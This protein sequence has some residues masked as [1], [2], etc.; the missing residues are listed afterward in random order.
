ML[1]GTYDL[2][3]YR[4]DTTRI[5][6]VLWHDAA[7]TQPVDVSGAVAKAQIRDRPDSTAVVA[8]LLCGGSGNTVT[9]TVPDA[10]SAKLGKNGFWDLQLTWS[11]G[12]VQTVVA[13]LVY[14]EPDVTRGTS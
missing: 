5:D 14:A 4:G 7:K 1:P 3:L 10:T 2:T 6:F 11:S 9:V 12:D 13:G 8:E